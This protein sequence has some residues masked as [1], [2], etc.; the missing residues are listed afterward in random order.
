MKSR[1]AG[2]R[3]VERALYRGRTD[4]VQHEIETGIQVPFRQAVMQP[5]F[6]L[7]H[8][9]EQEVKKM[10]EDDKIEP[11]NSPWCHVKNSKTHLSCITKP[12][13]KFVHHGILYS[14]THSSMYIWCMVNKNVYIMLQLTLSSPKSAYQYLIMSLEDI[15]CLSVFF[16]FFFF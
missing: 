3:I 12:N 15:W 9:A 11:S 13:T 14:M 4:L 1:K 5:Q 10:L 7:K 6:H 8:T 2:Q 16:F